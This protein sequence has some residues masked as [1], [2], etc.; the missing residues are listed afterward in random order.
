MGQWLVFFLFWGI[1]SVKSG[2][3]TAPAAAG[4]RCGP[5]QHLPVGCRT[6]QLAGA[7]LGTL[8]KPQQAAWLGDH[9]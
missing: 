8:E 7:H 2:G 9:R 4:P 1:Q 5:A 6:W 3:E